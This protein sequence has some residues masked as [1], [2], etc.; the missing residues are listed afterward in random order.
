VWNVVRM[1]LIWF[2]IPIATPTS[3]GR[4]CSKGHV[5]LQATDGFKVLLFSGQTSTSDLLEGARA[6]VSSA[7][8]RSQFI[9]PNVFLR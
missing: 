9:R 5:G 2:T 4:C 7:Y 3:A 1:R 6:Q 8:F